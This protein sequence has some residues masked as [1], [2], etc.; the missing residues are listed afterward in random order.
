[1][2]VCVCVCGVCVCCVVMTVGGGVGGLLFRFVLRPV[3]F[4]QPFFFF[5]FFFC[6]FYF[7][8]RVGYEGRRI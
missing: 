2:C 8:F 5:F 6:C 3:S 4:R 7:L 1:M